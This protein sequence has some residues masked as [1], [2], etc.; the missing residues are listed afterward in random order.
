MYPHQVDRLTAAADR[1]GLDALVAVASDNVR[2][3]TGFA[4][5]VESVYRDPGHRAFG[6]FTRRGAGLVVPMIDAIALADDPADVDVVVAYGE[7]TVARGGGDA[8]RRLAEWTERP[9]GDPV[10]ALR[11]VLVAL[12]VER[13]TVGVDGS[14]PGA[15]AWDGLAPISTRPGAGALAEARMVKSPYEIEAVARALHAAEQGA[16]AVMQMLKPGVT[17]REAAAVFE[18]DVARRGGRPYLTLVGFGPRAGLPAA[19]PSTRALRTGDLVRLDLGA[20]LDGYRA[21]VARAAVMGAPDERQERLYE[22]IAA[23]HETAIDTL[24]PGE[25]G[26]GVF[27]VTVAA[28]RAAGLAEYAR[29]HVGHGVGL[30]HWEIPVLAPADTT[31]LEEGMVIQVENAWYE[32][33]WGGVHL[34]DT[35]LVT[36][37]G[38]RSMNRS[39]RGLVVLD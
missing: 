2:Y 23:G 32:L 4:S 30:S 21:D 11:R 16:N 35:L 22:A 6:V 20:V 15:D 8:A 1:H 24:R 18:D 31:P 3:V 36:R 19:A 33:G 25:T 12:G 10:E 39:A 7:F 38:T 28:A 29:Q 26:A 9:T 27:D 14:G 13:G 5:A 34:K 37:G 17:E